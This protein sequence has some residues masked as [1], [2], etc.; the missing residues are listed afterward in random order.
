MNVVANPTSSTIDAA[1]VE[2]LADQY[3]GRIPLPS[4]PNYRDQ[5]LSCHLIRTILSN[6]RY[7]IVLRISP[8]T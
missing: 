1:D 2:T 5:D 7:G 3:K 4:V 6:N 8:S